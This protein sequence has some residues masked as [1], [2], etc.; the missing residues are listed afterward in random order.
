MRSMAVQNTRN[1]I[2]VYEIECMKFIYLNW[3]SSQNC[4]DLEQHTEVFFQVYC[5]CRQCY[6]KET[7]INMA[8]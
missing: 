6:L 3:I 8:S 5:C 7:D 1:R 4:V 2:I